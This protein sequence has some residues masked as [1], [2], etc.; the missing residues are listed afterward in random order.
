MLDAFKYKNYI[1]QRA[2]LSTFGT[3]L[4]IIM[5]YIILKIYIIISINC[6]TYFHFIKNVFHLTK[7]IVGGHSSDTHFWVI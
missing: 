3:V 1:Y 7:N 6:F 4:Q 2:L 5:I